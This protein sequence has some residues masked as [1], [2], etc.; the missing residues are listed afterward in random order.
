MKTKT[1]SVIIL[2]LIWA[3][4]F[5]AYCLQG[6]AYSLTPQEILEKV[7]EIR[8]PDRTFVFDLKVTVKRGEDESEAGFFVR[9]KDARKSLVLYKSPPSNRGRVL[10]MVEDNMWIY[11]PGT[12]RP[13]R[14]SPN[15]QIM[16]RV[17]NADVARVVYGLDYKPDSLEDD[18]IGD[19]EVLRMLLEAKTKGA[20]YR[21]INLWIEKDTFSPIK[22][23]FFAL[24]GRL[25]KTVYYKGYKEVLGKEMPTILEIHDAIKEAEVSI[26]EYSNIKLEDTPD[27]YFQK[28]FM[29]RV[30]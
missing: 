20:A 10:L 25:L 1:I 11:I 26:M 17:S 3:V 5:P 30:K 12:R 29:E 27:L 23:E 7:D 18:N 6:Q 24:S 2:I 9:V 19:R 21:R 4:P 22:A 8:A 16:G 15:Q 14:I 13:I 28:T